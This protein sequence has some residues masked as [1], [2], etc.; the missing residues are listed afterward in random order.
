MPT[1]IVTWF[2]YRTKRTATLTREVADLSEVE[3]LMDTVEAQMGTVLRID[4]QDGRRIYRSLVGVTDL[5]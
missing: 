3:A 2:D 1:V 4:D 5:Q